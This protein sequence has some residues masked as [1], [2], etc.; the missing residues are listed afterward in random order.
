[1]DAKPK[2]EG[3][4]PVTIRW[5]DPQLLSEGR[6]LETGLSLLDD[7]ET[8]RYQRLLPPEA[9]ILF[10]AAHILLRLTLSERYPLPPR[11][12][13]FETNDHGK[14]R[15]AHGLL[16]DPPHFNLAHTPGL[17]IL[18]LAPVP[19]GVDAEYTRREVRSLESLA[20]AFF[21][22]VE[23]EELT[24]LAEPA[25]SARFFEIWTL[26]EAYLKAGGVGM[27][28]GL[29]HFHFRMEGESATIVFDRDERQEAPGWWFRSLR[30]VRDWQIALA[31]PTGG[32]PVTLSD[33]DATPF[34]RQRLLELRVHGGGS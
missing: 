16:T 12:W 6:F 33:S 14:P 19:L 5:L 7:V 3:P 9:K 13:R 18:G 17:A 31:I 23:A 32:L 10:A 11:D 2:P 1:M 25:R 4:V 22:P 29:S 24:A 20:R 21:S 27:A 28:E 34:V 26:K 15:V 30:L 8:A